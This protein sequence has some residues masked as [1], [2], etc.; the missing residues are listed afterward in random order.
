LVFELQIRFGKSQAQWRG[1]SIIG[2]G[3]ICRT[4]LLASSARLG[5]HSANGRAVSI[6]D[7]GAL[8]NENITV[9]NENITV[10]GNGPQTPPSA[11]STISIDT[12]ERAMTECCV[13]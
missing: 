13:A 2:A 12:A 6:R 1:F 8:R 4:R 7:P 9:R 3:A 5:V 10:H 11:V